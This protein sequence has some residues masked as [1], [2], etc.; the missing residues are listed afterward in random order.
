MIPARPE[1][2]PRCQTRTCM[3]YACDP[4][5]VL[6]EPASLGVDDIRAAI[7]EGIDLVRSAKATARAL[8]GHAENAWAADKPVLA[9]SYAADAERV[10]LQ[11]YIAENHLY[12]LGRRLTAALVA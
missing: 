5:A 2:C 10:S 6:P 1:P 11:G 12:A 7:G 3:R 9:D 8:W 4:F